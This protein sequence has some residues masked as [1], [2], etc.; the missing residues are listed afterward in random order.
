MKKLMMKAS[1]ALLLAVGVG[2][3]STT[4]TYKVVDDKGQEQEIVARD[5][6]GAPIRVESTSVDK[7]AQITP[8][9]RRLIEGNLRKKAEAGKFYAKYKIPSDEQIKALV[10]FSLTESEMASIRQLAES[11]TRE[12]EKKIVWPMLIDAKKAKVIPEAEKFLSEGD[13]A[14]AREVI[15]RASTTGIEPVDAGIREFGYEFLNTK[16]NPR[17]WKLVE[18]NM[19]DKALEF[20]KKGA[21]DEGILWLKSVPRI[22]EYST[23]LDDRLVNV[24]AELVKLSV[25]EKDVQ[26]IVEKTKEMI[27]IAAKIYD[28]ADKTTNTV[29]GVA[30]NVDLEAYDAEVKKY[31]DTLIRYNCTESNADKIV[32]AFKRDA[33]PLLDPLYTMDSTEHA[34]LYLGTAAVNKRIDAYAERLTKW[35][36]RKRTLKDD[37]A[38]LIANGQYEEAKKLISEDVDAVVIASAVKVSKKQTKAL[39]GKKTAP[40]IVGATSSKAKVDAKA[41]SILNSANESTVVLEPSD[42]VFCG[43]V[44]SGIVRSLVAQREYVA[45]REFIW[46]VC[47]PK[48]HTVLTRYLEPIGKDLMNT[49]VNP[50]NWA[51]IEKSIS[52]EV[53]GF[54]KKEDY[55]N[56]VAWLEKYPLIK[57]YAGEVDA[58][59]GA[60]AAEAV[61][62]GVDG[63]VVAP[64]VGSNEEKTAEAANIADRTDKIKDRVI[65]GRKIKLDRFN[66]LLAE[67]RSVLLKNGCTAN[68]A[69]M[70]VAEFRDAMT[71][72]FKGLSEGSVEQVLHLGCNGLNDRIKALVAAKI[73]EIKGLEAEAKVKAEEIAKYNAEMQSRIDD[74]IKRVVALVK[75]ESFT[76]AR[77][78]IRDVELVKDAKWDA[79]MYAT[80]IGLLNSIVNPRQCEKLS[81][82][83]NQKIKEFYDNED[84]EGLKA[85]V[86][87]Y[88]FVRDTY[89]QILD[90][91]EQIKSAMLE[92]PI[93]EPDTVAY[94]ED[95]AKRLNEVMDKR[96][97]ALDYDHDF[98][99]LEKALQE[100]QQSYIKQHYN[101]ASAKSVCDCIRAEVKAMLGKELEPLTTWEMNE[102]LAALLAFSTKGLDEKIALQKAQ[103]AEEEAAKA[104]SDLLAAID[105]EVSFD[106]Q[107]AMAEDAISKQ[108]GI[109]C[110]EA[111]LEM[112][113]VLGNYARVLRLMKR[114]AAVSSEDATTLLVG[115]TYLGQASMFK[116]A[117]EL[118][119]DV[120]APAR[121]DPRARPALLVA[122]EKGNTEF[123]RLI[124]EA[125][126]VQT[127]TDANGNTALHYAMKNGNLAVARVLAKAVDVTAVNNK[128]ETAL[129]TAVRRN[130]AKPV[131]FLINLIKSD[132][133]EKTAVA[134]KAFVSHK[135]LAGEDAF[136]VACRADVHMV[137][138]PLFAAGAEF[139]TSH[140]VEAAASDR[141]AIAQW[142]VEH[143]ADV[144]ADGVMAAAFGS[145]D[146]EDTVTY[147]YLIHEGGV[148]LKRTPKCCKEIREAHKKCEALKNAAPCKDDADKVQ[149]SVVGNITFDVKNK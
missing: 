131:E 98:T 23:I 34:F 149:A 83:I 119:A 12:A 111:Y 84:Y 26:P 3:S 93:R 94:V 60:A 86:Q 125:K 137:L 28:D 113:A 57:V 143:G 82:E 33:Q 96:L 108:L 30:S 49:C 16:V 56:A 136:T 51:D 21:Y 142:L 70:L 109:K 127:V 40:I 90:A 32:A 18:K 91:I 73:G 116:R 128:G 36:E 100:I 6:S 14:N 146:D 134:R 41:I 106:A 59:L 27:R 115:A 135:N 76:E 92:M 79:K 97:G 133:Q 101:E 63:K 45:A 2:C 80:R 148:A 5:S 110:P 44:F 7:I 78:V 118:K 39:A 4:L 104:Y 75:E 67:Y 42:L 53:S 123:L 147:K 25:D 65:P 145:A 9:L 122:I 47:Y 103:K 107:I 112:N 69:D 130:Q 17:E 50:A 87:G 10:K 129:F 120:N 117:V 102:R 1:G 54:V 29:S 81:A 71:P 52:N 114:G 24:K 22:R 8:K 15:W 68:N 74:L 20:S 85:F 77:E 72:H 46:A 55:A 58:K 31:R 99:A 13:F 140:L 35:L 138:D 139:N 37:V 132:D 43:E 19:R 48:N 66:A 62:L 144:N 124:H 141:I 89:Q 38:K 88:P 126:G 105:A 11:M 64:A 121:R 61:K 95:L